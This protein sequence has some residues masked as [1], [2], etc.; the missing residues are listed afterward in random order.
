MAVTF[1]TLKPNKPHKQENQEKDNI[2]LFPLKRHTVAKK[3][4]SMTYVDIDGQTKN[5]TG[6]FSKT[7]TGSYVMTKTTIER[8]PVY[9]KEEP[10]YSYV[11]EH[12]SYIDDDGV[13]RIFNDLDTLQYDENSNTYVGLTET[14]KYNASTVEVFADEK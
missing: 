9:E 10:I 14:I 11:K 1:F 4:S 13:K 8:Y 2:V 12:F 6:S 5:V 3:P 7:E